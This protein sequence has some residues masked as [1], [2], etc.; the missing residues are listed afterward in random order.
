[1]L[2]AAGL[3][4]RLQPITLDF[5]KALVPLLGVP[6]AQFAVDA[7]IRA[8][9]TEIVANIHHHP[10]QA[11]AGLRSL[12]LA[13]PPQTRLIISDESSQLLGSGGGIRQALPLF[14]GEAFFLVNADVLSDLSLK[15]LG[16]Y[17]QMMHRKFGVLVTLAILPGR[18]GAYREIVSDPITGLITRLGQVVTGKPYFMGAAV[19]EPEALTH[20]AP[21]PSEFVPQI[22]APAVRAGR[23]CAYSANCLWKDVGTPELWFDAHMALLD[24][25]E[26]GSLAEPLRIRL[27]TLNHRIGERIWVDRSLPL[28]FDRSGW[29]GPCY[30]GAAAGVQELPREFGPRAFLYGC[31]AQAHGPGI[32]AFGHWLPMSGV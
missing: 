26:T 27:E 11:E 7:L 21:G 4:T 10:K 20:L 31:N 9:V 19:L 29:A 17:H 2:M 8:G 12:D 24:G 22:L 14:E 25:I 6:M 28:V 32:G 15:D 3:G 16:E 1:M 23:A 5:P 13:G 18:A 30:F